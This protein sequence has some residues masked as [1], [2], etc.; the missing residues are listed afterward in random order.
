MVWFFAHLGF[1][2][3]GSNKY[4]YYLLVLKQ[5]CFLHVISVERWRT[6]GN[7]FEIN[8]NTLSIT[9]FAKWLRFLWLCPSH[10]TYMLFIVRVSMVFHTKKIFHQLYNRLFSYKIFGVIPTFSNNFTISCFGIIIYL[11][12]GTNIPHLR[13]GKITFVLCY[14]SPFILLCKYYLV[15]FLCYIWACG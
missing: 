12:I 13:T 5:K 11:R 7:M 10:I 4:E 14:F 6:T 8:S 9:R 1:S 3:F 2:V 15:R